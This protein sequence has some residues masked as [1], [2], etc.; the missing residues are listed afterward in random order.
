MRE[1]RNHP[2]T[3]AESDVRATEEQGVFGLRV[4]LT[5][6]TFVSARDVTDTARDIEELLR[7]LER[8]IDPQ[9]K[10]QAT[11][12]WA[13]P[14]PALQFIA[15]PNGASAETLMH[16]VATAQDG[17]DAARLAAVTNLPAD[18]PG[19]F[20]PSARDR[21][22]R[23]LRRLEHL[24]SII[25]TATGH[26][27]IEIDRTLTDGKVIHGQERPH[28]IFSSVDGVLRMLSGGEKVVWAGLREHR[29][30]AYVRCTFDAAT[31]RTSLGSLWEQRVTVEGMV[32]YDD[33]R[34][35]KSIIDVKRVSPREGPTNLARFA[36]SVPDLTGGLSDDE[37]VRVLRRND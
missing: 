23:V 13:E 19:E 17:F 4:Q 11:W 30:N 15:T 18:W 20:S 12:K 7:E 10:A 1:S 31:W 26:E 29:T 37:Y 36:G 3:V 9:S 5:A 2:V 16:V 33:R 24:H 21:T 34:R 8:R 32:A 6:E 22:E 28:R 25:V 35:P 27:P 14:D